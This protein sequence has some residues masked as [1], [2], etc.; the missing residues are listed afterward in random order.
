MRALSAKTRTNLW[1]LAAA[2]D[3][4][5]L[6]LLFS[7]FEDHGQDAPTQDEIR[8]ATGLSKQMITH[9]TRALA[10]T[11]FIEVATAKGNRKEVRVLNKL[12]LA[13]AESVPLIL[14][15]Y[16]NSIREE[17]ENGTATAKPKSLA[18]GHSGVHLKG[19]WSA[20]DI[21][22]D[23]DWQKVEVILLKY[24]RPSQINP[25]FLTKKNKFATLLEVVGQVDFD[26]Y[27]KWYRVEKYPRMK[28]N[29]GLFLYPSMLS[30]FEDAME[31]DDT[32]LNVSTNME[33]SAAYKKLLDEQ[34][35]TLIAEFG[36][37]K[38]EKET[39]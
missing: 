15:V 37:G 31:D 29:F 32:Y 26:A 3:R 24:F 8:K 35:K 13:I 39:D 12:G 11:G 14:K 18:N 23:E 17:R 22:D 4:Y 5:Q 2:S 33:N 34:E 7:Y 20:E 36:E 1:K 10:A 19:Q 28:F 16:S 9:T 25:V 30:E 38:N 6:L 27:C 21:R